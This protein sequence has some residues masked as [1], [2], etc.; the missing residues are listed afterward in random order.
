MPDVSTVNSGHCITFAGELFQVAEKVGLMPLMRFAHIADSGVDAEDMAGLAAMYDLLEQCI[1][2]DE[3]QRFQRVATKAR[4]DGEQ[5]MGVVKDAIEAITAR[6]TGRPSDSS[7]GPTPTPP[8]SEAD[9][10]SRVIAR[11]EESGRPD[12]ALVVAQAQGLTG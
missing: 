6:P 10:S 12:L 4:A 1:A 2:E 7:A 3:W 9:Y 5:L 11:L 8:R